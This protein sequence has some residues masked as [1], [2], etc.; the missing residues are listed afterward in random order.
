MKASE[1]KRL[2]PV[3]AESLTNDWCAVLSLFSSIFRKLTAAKHPH[4]FGGSTHDPQ[5][6]VLLKEA[7]FRYGD[8]K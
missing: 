2:C 7:G 3:Q 8:Q 6:P 4:Y 1:E 5:T